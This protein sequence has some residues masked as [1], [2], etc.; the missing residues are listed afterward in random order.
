MNVV[1]TPWDQDADSLRATYPHVQA[2]TI[3]AEAPKRR[4]A[5]PKSRAQPKPQAKSQAKAPAKSQAKA[6]PKKA[7]AVQREPTPEDE[8][9]DDGLKIE[10]P[11][12]PPRRSNHSVPILREPVHQED[13]ESSEEESD[14][15]EDERDRDVDVLRLPSPAHDLDDNYLDIEAELTQALDL[16]VHGGDESSESEEE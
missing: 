8:E 5:E 9:S 7:K 6:Q 16:D 3:E 13:R 2:T 14:A 11:D 4:K 1:S 10:Y 15:G 12:G